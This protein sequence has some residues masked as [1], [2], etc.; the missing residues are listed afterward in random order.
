M[1]E[2]E[3]FTNKGELCSN[4]RPFTSTIFEFARQRKFKDNPT[5]KLRHLL[6]TVQGKVKKVQG[7]DAQL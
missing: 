6:T 2:K 7:N 3:F 5:W 4:N 1:R